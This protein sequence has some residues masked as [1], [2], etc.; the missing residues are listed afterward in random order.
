MPTLGCW[1]RLFGSGRAKGRVMATSE[2]HPMIEGDG[3]IVL[4]LTHKLKLW[5]PNHFCHFHC[6][7]FYWNWNNASAFKG[8]LWSSSLCKSHIWSSSHTLQLYL[9]LM[10]LNIIVMVMLDCTYTIVCYWIQ[11]HYSGYL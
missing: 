1:R 2:W 5:P 6:G 10:L 4:Q 11:G 9:P 8:L 7:L 3:T